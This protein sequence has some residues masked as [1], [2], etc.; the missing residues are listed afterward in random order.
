LMRFYATEVRKSDEIS[1]LN[2]LPLERLAE[3]LS[4]S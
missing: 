4:H 2:K 1:A 3:R